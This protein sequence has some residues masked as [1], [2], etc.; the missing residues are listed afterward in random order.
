[1]TGPRAAARWAWIALGLLSL[2][3]GTVGV[4]LPGLPTTVFVLGAAACF[5]RSSP[6]LEAWLLARPR[7]GRSIADHRAGLGMPRRAKAVAVVSIAVAGALSAVATRQAPALAVA[8]VAA[9]VVGIAVV[10][11]RVP[12]KEVVLAD[13]ARAAPGGPDRPDS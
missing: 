6:R 5:A 8:I 7:I 1:M 11:W 2:A 9:C 13:R 3:V 10:T 12:T 4:V